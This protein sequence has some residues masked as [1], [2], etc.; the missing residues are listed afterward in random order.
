[1]RKPF[2]L[3][4]AVAIVA[5]AAVPVA[6]AAKTP[7]LAVAVKDNSFSPK[8]KSIKKGTKITWTWKGEV[9]HNVTLG[10]APKGVKPYPKD[11]K[12]QSKTQIKGTYVRTLTVPGKYTYF[13]TIHAGMDQTLTVTK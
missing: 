12:A 8:K 9:D 3:I 13:C 1:M 5:V 11:K 2:I 10:I 6:G 7:T 4:A